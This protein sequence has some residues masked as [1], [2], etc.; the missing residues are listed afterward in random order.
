MTT[1]TPLDTTIAPLQ[2]S[3][4]A[5]RQLTDRI[6]AT[7]AELAADLLLAYQGGAHL[8]LGYGSWGD[9]YEA[10]FQRDRS[11]GYQILNA[12]RVN[13]TFASTIVDSSGGPALS[14]GQARALVPLL[15]EPEQLV[16]A[17]HEAQERY[18]ELPTAAQIRQV[19]GENRD[20][21]ALGVHGSSESAAIEPRAAPT[22]HDQ[23]DP[24]PD[25]LTPAE[26]AAAAERQD[27]AAFLQALVDARRFGLLTYK[28]ERI[29]PLLTNARDER[30]VDRGLVA[31]QRWLSGW[32]RTLRGKY[33]FAG[34]VSLRSYLLSTV[35]PLLEGEV[36]ST[37]EY[38][39][40]AGR[41]RDLVARVRL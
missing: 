30:I 26:Q 31:T 24:A 12:A 22:A 15:S 36:A 13:L 1:D 11:R 41:I 25:A 7:A 34:W 20:E 4:E 39:D 8:A 29:A 28:P 23:E 37:E 2:L 10:E 38:R 6:K 19:V 21:T 9:F 14:E 5:A 40:L 27:L 33:T 17:W 18:G 32:D 35:C 16:A 3:P